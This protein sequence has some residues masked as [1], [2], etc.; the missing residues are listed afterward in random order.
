MILLPFLLAAL[1]G[2]AAESTYYELETFKTPSGAVLEV[3]GLD[4]FSDGR[5]AVS[6]RRGQVWIVDG[7]LGDDISKAKFSLFAE[8]LREGLGLNVVDDQI[9]VMQRGEVSRLLDEDGDGRCDRIDTISNSWGVSGNYHEFGFGLPQD[10]Q[11]NFYITLNVS[12]SNPWWLGK[13]PV[14]FRGWCLQIAPNGATRPFAYGLRSPC[15]V[16]TN[17]AGDL[18]VTD[19]QGDWV[20]SSP[21]YHVTEGAFFG[22]PASL[23]WTDEYRSTN[24]EPSYEIP[25]AAAANRKPPAIWIPYRW[26]RSTGNLT[27]DSSEGQFGPFQG[28]LFVTEM[29]NGVVLRALMEKV[30]GEY[31]GAVVPFRSELGSA[32][33]IAFGPDGSL[34]LGYTNRGWGGRAPADGLARLRWT[35]KTPLDFHEIHLAQDGFNITLTEP[36]AKGVTID[37]STVDAL[38][39][40]YNYWWEYGSPPQHLVPFKAQ[41]VQIS[42]DRKSLRLT[43]A[44]LTAATCLD[45]KLPDH[46]VTEDG[47]P[48]LHREFSYTINQLPEGPLCQEQVSKVVS[49]PPSK[50]NAMEGWLRLTYSDATALWDFEGWRLTNAQPTEGDDSILSLTEGDGALVPVKEGAQFLGK[51]NLGDHKGEVEFQLTR[52]GS[53]ELWLLGQY[54]I[55]LT[56][57]PACG[58][59]AGK[60]PNPAIRGYFGKGQ[61]NKL[62]WDIQAARYDQTGN[63]TRDA[64]LRSLRINGQ[65]MLENVILHA[66][67]EGAP[68]GNESALGPVALTGAP[69]RCAFRGVM[70]QPARQSAPQDGWS[71]VFPEDEFDDWLSTGDAEWELNDDGILIGTGKAGHLFSKRGD[72]KNFELKGRFKINDGGNSGFYFRVQAEEGWPPGY[73]A[74]INSNFPDPQ[75]TGS[76]YSLD[77][78]TT[79]IVP[80]N[81]WFD[82]EIRCVDTDAGTHITISVNGA[83]ITDFVDT[84]RLHGAG[85]IAL[86]QHHE[87]S[88][89]EAKN[90]MIRPLD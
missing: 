52:G 27:Y 4:F 70:V 10:K 65:P 87:G 37:P 26:S 12:F 2:D 68:L 59:V 46:L 28:Q 42:E 17:A 89:I 44:A 88:R 75:K 39:Y 77:S 90:I 11:G 24:S 66:P 21:I 82:Y 60:Q 67:D 30:R 43:F 18:F 49:P 13:S 51:I 78:I 20:A 86:Q 71:E 41:A 25:S 47:R 3:G 22:H 15:G 45:V 50:E 85:H 57:N 9:H 80:E 23:M 58:T 64:V 73:E 76:L 5:L 38:Q 48:L 61:W 32:C 8:G 69:H 1:Q 36:L 19:N 35:G 72:Y 81:A 56:D 74:Q 79:W 54:A 62:T 6:T 34:M 40:D 29:T 31:Q 7:A 83:E 16:G 14:P 53:A 84:E 63:K 33:R 55:K